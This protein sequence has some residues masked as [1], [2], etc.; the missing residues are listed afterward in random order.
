MN[1]ML[2]RIILTWAGAI[3]LGCV[4]AAAGQEPEAAKP[5]EKSYGRTPDSVIPYRDFRDPY[6][7]FFQEPMEFRGAYTKAAS[8]ETPSTARIGFFGPT[9]SAPDADL[10]RDMLDGVTLA[11][12]QANASGGFEGI[13]FELIVRPDLAIWGASSNEMVAFKYVDDVL[14]VIGSIDGANT[15]IALRVALK[16]E[17]MLVNTGDTDPTLTETR[18]PWMLR[19]MA[20]DRQ[21]C[22]ALAHHIFHER[23]IEK[24][25]AFRVNNHYGRMGIAEFR[26]AARRLK[27]PLRAEMRWNYGDRDFALQLDRIAELKP[28]AIVLWGSAADAAAVVNEIRRREMPVQIFGSDR[29]ASATFLELAGANAEGVV[30]AA[31]YDPTRQDARLAAFRASFGKRFGH[32]PE[33]FA[34]HAY[35][36]TNLLIAAIREAGLDRIAIRDTMYA[37]THYDGVT[38]PIDF[39][40]TLNDVG[41]VFLAEVRE[42][43]FVYEEVDFAVPSRSALGPKP[44]SARDAYR[45]LV[46]SPPAARS[47]LRAAN[48]NSIRVG[49]FLPLDEAGQSAVRGIRLA[50]EDDRRH[51]GDERSIELVVR[52]ARGAWGDDSGALVEMVMDQGVVA[53]IGSTERRGTHLAEMLAAKMHFPIVTLSCEDRTVHQIPLA[54]VFS[55]TPGRILADSAFTRRF[56]E[57]FGVSAGPYGGLGYDA[58][59]LLAGAIRSGPIPGGR[60]GVRDALAGSAWHAGVT[61]TFR[62][63]PLGRRVNRFPAGLGD[64]S[65]ALEKD[66][67]GVYPKQLRKLIAGVSG[68]GAFSI[69]DGGSAPRHPF[70]IRGE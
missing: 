5:V 66:S 57:Q 3:A 68:D 37:I 24:V 48:G 61:G 18:I 14:A 11:I 42:G 7:R 28:D 20:D 1:Q 63:D 50:F 33:T 26:D 70:A 53:L 31:T 34:A 41:P 16:T 15:H 51:H 6:K 55:V 54:W 49:C 22:Y 23:G 38:G 2:G 27:H 35:D 64:V 36:G 39:D 25:A 10:G 13:P 17:M 4:S 59:V 40:T 69:N 12:E 47:P 32:D 46:Q 43:K 9:G 58:G 21:Q 8:V 62:F 56:S 44:P 30:A 60:K 67:G 29:L 45:T 52:D 19:C 65:K